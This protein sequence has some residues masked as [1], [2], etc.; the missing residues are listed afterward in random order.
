MKSPFLSLATVYCFTVFSAAVLT[1]NC[2][3]AQQ[4]AAGG[5]STEVKDPCGVDHSLYGMAEGLPLWC[6]LTDFECM[7]LKNA[8]KARQGEADA[9]FALAI[10]ASGNVRDMET[11]QKYHATVLDFITKVRD[12]IQSVLTQYDKGKVLYEKMCGYFF[13]HKL[14]SDEMKGY[15]FKQ[16]QLSEIFRSAKYNCVSSALLYMVLARYFGLTVKGVSIPSHIFVQLEL[17]NAK[18]IE[19]ETTVRAGF[20]IVHDRNFYKGNSSWFGSRNLAQSSYND[21]LNRTILDPFQVIYLNMTNQHT[22]ERRMARQDRYRLWEAMG[23]LAPDDTICVKAR[24]S[25]FH[26]EFADLFNCKNSDA[27]ARMF[28]FAERLIPAIRARWASNPA[29]LMLCSEVEFDYAHTLFLIGRVD[30]AIAL[31][32]G[33]T[34]SFRPTV[35]GKQPA[36]G[37]SILS[38]VN[39]AIKILVEQNRF[40]DGVQ[41]LKKIESI[42]VIHD[43]LPIYYC[44][45]YN[46]WGARIE[47]MKKHKE[48]I[49]CFNQALSYATKGPL[50]SIVE[51][52]IVA[53][54]INNTIEL[55]KLKE[56]QQ[57]VVQCTTALQYA[58]DET[59]RKQIRKSVSSAY[60]NWSSELSEKKDWPRA[61]A[62]DSSALLFSDTDELRTQT[63]NLLSDIYTNWGNYLTG[64]GD[65]NAAQEKYGLGVKAAQNPQK[66]ALVKK[67]L[68]ILYARWAIRQAEQGNHQEAKMLID[69]CQQ[70]CP[71]ATE[72][73]KVKERL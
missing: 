32:S 30:S 56:W 7:A 43:S 68:S 63:N 20:D 21:Y 60:Y 57:A 55:W 10:F 13:K 54:S 67:N 17:P 61:I 15:S 48:A 4:T 41:L 19:I 35:K 62:K 59:L 58:K 27:A 18:D 9:L 16:S 72:C 51:N 11:Y 8:D 6:E 45:F 14:L 66:I 23:Y 47:G 64:E 5:K 12:T 37:T 36:F 69:K 49:D 70:Q 34:G 38:T 53:A 26:N 44:N 39:D 42:P 33:L 29:I 24:L 73:L 65:F 25:M 50:R 3:G 31:M 22:E 1:R 52:N 40:D 2:A 46:S 28:P 71:D